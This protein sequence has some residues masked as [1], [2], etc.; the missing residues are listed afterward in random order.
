M[1]FDS[2]CHLDDP[3]LLPGL[4]AHLAE[5]EAAGISAFLV[6]GVA[7]A[8]WPEIA[9]LHRRFSRVLPAFG[10]HPTHA[11]LLTPAVLS[12]LRSLCPFATA[13]GEIG[14]DY[15][16]VTPGRE[17]QIDAFRSQLEVASRAGL[18]VLIHCR[19]AFGDLLAIMKE[20]GVGRHGGVMHGFSGAPEIALD[21][22]RLGLHISL[23]GS[24]TYRN[25]RRPLLVAKQ[26]PLERLLLETD[27]PDLAPEPHRGSLNLPAYLLLTANRVAALKGIPLEELAAATTANARALFRLGP[28]LTRRPAA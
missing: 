2:H 15:T 6:P 19:K 11:H 22:L 18:P 21:C 16:L 7:P 27:A 5:A 1:F 20:Q 3:R 8:G 13:I 14:L 12:E 10:V 17:L 28:D 23:A 24:V 9:S 26:V 25:A 4:A